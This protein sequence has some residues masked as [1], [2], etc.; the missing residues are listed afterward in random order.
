MLSVPG[1][2]Q[3]VHLDMGPHSLQMFVNIIRG[4]FPDI[5]SHS[6]ALALRCAIKNFVQYGCGPAQRTGLAIFRHE[7]ETTP[8]ADHVI[9]ALS[10]AFAC[11]DWALL[12]L[13][14]SKFYLLDG[15]KPEVQGRPGSLKGIDSRREF[16]FS[17]FSLQ[18]FENIPPRIILA[19]L[20]ARDEVNDGQRL[21]DR[22]LFWSRI[23]D[24]MRELLSIDG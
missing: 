22:Q 5:P 24:K 1:G 7:L 4:D 20:R 19:Y 9:T 15:R 12:H 2:E 23:A 10:S 8:K 11:E 14:I 6:D 17:S 3:E 13:A 21:Q 16:D 18:S